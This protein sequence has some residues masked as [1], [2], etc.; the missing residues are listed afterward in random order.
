[1]KMV[2]AG[3]GFSATINAVLH[4]CNIVNVTHGLGG[5]DKICGAGRPQNC[6][7]NLS[8]QNLKTINRYYLSSVKKP[9]ILPLIFFRTT[10]K[11]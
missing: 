5:T 1:M 4:Q 9:A 8:R 10:D 2:I 7:N 11:S 3:M 6:Y